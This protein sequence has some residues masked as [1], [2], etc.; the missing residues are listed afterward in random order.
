VGVDEGEALLALQEMTG[1]YA[2]IPY[3]F[4]QF[5]R[6]GFLG[7]RAVAAD[8]VYEGKPN[9]VP[10][11]LVRAVCVLGDATAA[12]MRLQEYADAGA[13]VVLSYPVATPNAYSSVMATLAALAPR[14][15]LTF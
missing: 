10:E 15:Q 11:Q 3:Y 5:G 6:M 4:R 13:D 8:A 12:G 14:P 2:M 1:Q 9:E 7:E